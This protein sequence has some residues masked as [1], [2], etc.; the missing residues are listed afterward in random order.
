[1]LPKTRKPQ[2]ATAT[3]HTLIARRLTELLRLRSPR[4][5][6]S[7][8]SVCPV[9]Q[10]LPHERRPRPELAS[11]LEVPAAGPLQEVLRR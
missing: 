2:R 3:K 1:M 7:C 6:R 8:R 5:H 10:P 11:C 4:C 9:R